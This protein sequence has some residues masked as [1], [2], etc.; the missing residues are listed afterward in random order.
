MTK[1]QSRWA[2][3]LGVAAAALFVFLA[4]S[5]SRACGPESCGMPGCGSK[6]ACAAGSCGCVH[7]AS[8]CS[9]SPQANPKEAKVPS[10]G[11]RVA[12]RSVSLRVDGMTCE[13]CPAKIRK[14]LEKL[15]GVKH[16]SVSLSKKT[17]VVR[18]DPTR[19]SVDEL[20][21]AID[22]EGFQASPLAAEKRS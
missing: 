14:T 5:G 15:V 20:I 2:G 18:F 9:M 13:D 7:G 21:Q 12:V 1:N 4:P 6:E 11:T 22:Q 17:A 3:L 8:G 16:T 19:I 10:K